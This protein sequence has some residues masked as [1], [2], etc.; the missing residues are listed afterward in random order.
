MSY[1]P[2]VNGV[3]QPTRPDFTIKVLRSTS[4][5]RG[6]HETHFEVVS[7]RA[8]DESGWKCLDAVGL[9]GMGQAYYVK[10]TETITDN[11]PC[12][13]VD[14]RT[15]EVLP[16]QVFAYNG[17]P[18]TKTYGYRYSAPPSPTR[19]VRSSSYSMPPTSWLSRSTATSLA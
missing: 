17:E 1:D 2:N 16:G 13:N 14:K 9:I 15:G 4:T 12:V 19:A 3:Y 6:Y 11:V 7:K 8:I 5:S 18:I 10:S